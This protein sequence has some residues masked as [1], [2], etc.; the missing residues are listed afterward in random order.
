MSKADF[1]CDLVEVFNRYCQMTSKEMDKAVKR[2]L[3][4]GARQLQAKTKE[5]ATAGMKTRNNKQWYNGHI[6]TFNDKIEDAV[7]IGK[8]EGDFENE[9]SLKVHV[10]GSRKKG[11]GT[12]RFRMLEKGTNDRE[13]KTWKGKPLKKNRRLGKLGAGWWFRSARQEIFPNLPNIYMSEIQ[14]AVEKINNTE[15]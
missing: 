4:Q 6:I 13:A 10:M 14:K 1:E 15:V 9:Q 3:Y 8:Y 11:S 2:A 7:I 5:N 12:Y